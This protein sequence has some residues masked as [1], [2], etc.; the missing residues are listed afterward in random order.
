MEDNE[1]KKDY[2]TDIFDIH[3]L[4]R[5]FPMQIKIGHTFKS[6]GFQKLSLHM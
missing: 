5:S 2:I 6:Q 4:I 1:N 3:F